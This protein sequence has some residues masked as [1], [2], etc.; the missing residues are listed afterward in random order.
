MG[1]QKF[2]GS[3]ADARIKGQKFSVPSLLVGDDKP[4]DDLAVFADGGCALAIARLAPQ[5][6][7][8]FH[9]PVEGTVVGVKD[10]KGELR[11]LFSQVADDRRT[12][13]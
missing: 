3:Q 1:P 5:D 8:R 6:Y 9:S 7:H 4:S 12:V 13:Q 2:D 11:D 10:I